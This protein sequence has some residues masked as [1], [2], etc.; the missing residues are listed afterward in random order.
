[1]IIK[2][3]YCYEREKDKITISLIKPEQDYQINYRL[4]ADDGKLLTND[5][6]TFTPCIDVISSEGWYEVDFDSEEL[7]QKIQDLPEIK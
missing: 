6:L 1:M 7:E 4:I 2:E 3:I 5:D